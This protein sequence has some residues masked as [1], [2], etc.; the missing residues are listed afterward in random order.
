MA[1]TNNRFDA[2]GVVVDWI[3]ACKQRR[4]DALLDLYDDAAI[5]EC[6][7]SGSFNGRSEMERYWRPRL[8]RAGN[9][10]FAIDAL[11]PE[12][13]GISLDYRGYDGRIMRTHFRFTR[14]G[15]IRLTACEPVKSTAWRRTIG[16]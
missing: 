15:K 6:C 2:V 12:E 8:A 10:A 4:L 5:V 7:E 11:T 13:D 3:D 16:H 1:N 9:D 14:S